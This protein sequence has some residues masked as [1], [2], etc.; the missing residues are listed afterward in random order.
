MYIEMKRV[1][2]AFSIVMAGAIWTAGQDGLDDLSL[3]IAEDVAVDDAVAGSLPE[4]DA[5]GGLDDLL[6]D[7][8]GAPSADDDLLGEATLPA[9]S[10][11]EKGDDDLSALFGDLEDAPVEEVPSEPVAVEEDGGLDALFEDLSDTPEATAADPLID[12]AE[13]LGLGEGDMGEAAP[14]AVGE[15]VEDLLGDLEPAV[16]EPAAD[17]GLDDLLG[18]VAADPVAE[19][20]AADMG[21]DDLLGDV[22]AEPV[23]EEPAADMDDLLGALVADEEPMEEIPAPVVEEPATELGLDDL[24]G[25]LDTAVEP[26]PVV[27]PVPVVEAAPAAAPIEISEDPVVVDE[28]ALDDSLLSDLAN[29]ARADMAVTQPAPVAEAPTVDQIDSLLD[30]LADEGEAAVTP[31]APAVAAPVTATPVAAPV[32]AAPALPPMS[33]DTKRLYTLEEIKRRAHAA[34]GIESLTAGEKA[35]AKRD[36]DAAIRAF[37]QAIA[38]IPTDQPAY[39]PKRANARRGL[40]G[41]S[42]LKA[43]SLERAG[44]YE[45]AKVAA[46]QAVSLGYARAES[47]LRRI[48]RRIDG[49]PIEPPPTIDRR[50]EEP[51]YKE[52]Q[53]EIRRRLKRGREA[54]L[55]GEYNLAVQAFKSVLAIDAFNKE[56]IKML[57]SASQKSYDRAS[58]EVEAVRKSM[59]DSVRKSWG[60]RTYDLVAPTIESEEPGEGTVVTDPVVQQEEI[61][62]EKLERI[63]LPQVEFRSANIRDVVELLGMQSRENDNTGLPGGLGVNIILQLGGADTGAAAAPAADPFAADPFGAPDAGGGGSGSDPLITFSAMSIKLREAIQVVCD[64]ANLKFKIRENVLMIV[65]RDWTDDKIETRLYNVLPNV[66]AR[67]SELSSSVISAR[68]SSKPNNPFGGGGMLEGERFDTAGD[69]DW[70]EFFGSFG[71]EWP[72]KSSVKYVGAL[73][74]MVVANTADNLTVFE[75]VL[76]YL[77]VVPFQIEIEARFIEVAQQD[78]D[79]LGLEWMI[80]D[81]WEL[82]HKPGSG[83]TPGSSE[84]LSI[85]ANSENGGFTTGLRNLVRNAPMAA[86]GVKDNLMTIQSFLT[87]PELAVVVHAIQQSGHTDLLSAPKVTTQSGQ[88]A[89]LKVV[90]EYIYPTE[91]ET[92][93]I[94]GNNNQGNVGGANQSQTIGAVVTPQSFETREVG[95]ILNVMPQVSPEGQ[96]INLQLKPQVVSEPEWRNYGSTYTSY[97]PN[98]NPLT[99]TLNMEQPFFHTRSIDTSMLIYNGATVVMGGMITEVRTDVDDRIPVLGSIPVLGNLFRSRY[100]HSEKRNLLIFVTA[101]LVDPSGRPLETETNQWDDDFIR[102]IVGGGGTTRE[103]MSA[104]IQ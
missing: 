102:T 53:A 60:P 41:A 97:D 99:Q 2:V 43:L 10:V 32:V 64:S 89:E 95:V 88:Q 57:H 29:E 11:A 52:K 34:H 78:L 20:P 91:F 47:A 45:Q 9:E 103:S 35:L 63:I 42:Y 75:K 92:S 15:G 22:A 48:Q 21:L 55:T 96:M 56:A 31:E 70:K 73:G 6:A 8:E 59:M 17:M 86:E 62:R 39:E 30:Q 16:E 54:Y 40:A 44:Q 28:N 80:T 104:E 87:N 58:M 67:I 68:K 19:A 3:L 101:R 38:Y 76:G 93:G 5:V 72:E 61:I 25:D 36:Y 74:K 7:L 94:S 51:A 1:A 4:D 71:V 83:P 12:A 77:N 49:P 23:V 84:R 50:W 18:D 82:M 33:T 100:E 81:D 24:L 14:A 46:K 65:H 66:A 90:T 85:A 79:S 13:E 69:P 37:E 98:G 26:E 27:E